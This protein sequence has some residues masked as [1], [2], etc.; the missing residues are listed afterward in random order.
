MSSNRPL[1]MCES[2][3]QET[4]PVE[5]VTD[6]AHTTYVPGVHY[7]RKNNVW[8]YMYNVSNGSLSEKGGVGMKPEGCMWVSV[9]YRAGR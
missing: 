7:S 5:R 2:I 8:E 3:I 1:E 6:Y 4:L 9:L